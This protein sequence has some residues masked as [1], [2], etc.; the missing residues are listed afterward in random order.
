MA[1]YRLVNGILPLAQDHKKMN[2]MI[3]SEPLAFDPTLFSPHAQSLISGLLERYYC[4][5]SW[6]V[7]STYWLSDVYRDPAK[8]LGSGVCGTQNIKNH[9]F[10]A[11]VNWTK[12]YKRQIEPP[13]K[14]H[15][16][17]SSSS[18][19]MHLLCHQGL[20]AFP[21]A[22]HHRYL[23]LQRGIHRRAS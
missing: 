9:P 14:P 7:T 13:Y 19:L 22:H 1:A 17:L 2:R 18:A 20:I 10:F 23:L 15:L 12:L 11:S 4:E 21:A 8:R 16:V 6:C 3:L 5:A